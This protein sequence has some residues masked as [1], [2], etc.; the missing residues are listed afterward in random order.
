MFLLA[1][2]WLWTYPKNA[3]IVASRFKL[4]NGYCQGKPLWTWIG[5][6]AALKAKKIVWGPHLDSRN[7]RIYV[8]TVDGTDFNMWEK[9]HPTLPR[10]KQLCSHKFNHA[11]LK[12]EIALSVYE[13]KCVWI[14]GPHIGG[15][16]D[17][18][19]FREGLKD[20]IRPGKKAIADRGYDTNHVD[21]QMLAPPNAVDSKRLNNFKSRARLRQ[22][23]FN[24]RLKFF[25]SLS[26]TFRHGIDKHKLVLEAV[27]V[28]VQYHMDNGKPVFSV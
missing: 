16:H 7:T 6:I 3:R 9:K 20:K 4:Y 26:Q 21:E 15:K 8:V 17:L 1:H 23:T 24:G 25:A 11:A 10:N 19:I 28:T 2:Y 18:T 12:Y 22:E 13:S 5:R 14:S 27:C